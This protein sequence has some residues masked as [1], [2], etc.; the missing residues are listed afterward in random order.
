MLKITVLYSYYVKDTSYYVQPIEVQFSL[1][2]LC[3]LRLSNFFWT[4]QSRGAECTTTETEST[5]RSVLKAGAVLST[6]TLFGV[7][8]TVFSIA[9]SMEKRPP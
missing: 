9:K 2:F 4:T 8:P 1:L 7:V 3:V 5:R 6:F